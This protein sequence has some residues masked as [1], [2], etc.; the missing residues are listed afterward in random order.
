[1]S[2]RSPSSTISCILYGR[3]GASSSTRSVRGSSTPS[4]QTASGTPLVC[5]WSAV[6]QLPRQSSRRATRRRRMATIIITVD[7]RRDNST[8]AIRF[9]ADRCVDCGVPVAQCRGLLDQSQ[10]V[11]QSS[12]LDQEMHDGQYATHMDRT[13]VCPSRCVTFVL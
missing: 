5:R 9:R 7:T 12:R 10:T 13:S 1:V 4:S 6:N 3:L 2:S 8:G 11:L